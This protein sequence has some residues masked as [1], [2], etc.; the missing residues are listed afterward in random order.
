MRVTCSEHIPGEQRV[1]TAHGPIVDNL[2]EDPARRAT[3]MIDVNLTIRNALYV[4]L[5]PPR[6]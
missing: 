3:P 2:G 1:D 6:T 5:L 4:Q